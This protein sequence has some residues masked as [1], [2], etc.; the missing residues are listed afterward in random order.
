MVAD[1][2]AQLKK[3]LGVNDRQKLDEY[4]TSVRDVEMRIDRMS[5]PVNFDVTPHLP[6]EEQP[7]EI[8]AHIRLMY[9]LMVLAFKTD[10]TRVATFML[11]NEGSTDPFRPS[12]SKKVIMNFRTIKKIPT[13]WPRSPRSTSSSPHSLLTS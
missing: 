1:D 8:E 3:S 11:A 6:P 9:D 7:D 12:A 2:A 10:T 4:F 5:Q 13:R